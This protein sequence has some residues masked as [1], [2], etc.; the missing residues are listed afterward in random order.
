MNWPRIYLN[1]STAWVEEIM[2]LG[3]SQSRNAKYERLLFHIAYRKG[4]F[5]A[6]MI[7]IEITPEGETTVSVK[8]VKGKSCEKI[9]EAIEHA[10]GK[11][12]ETRR[13]SEYSAPEQNAQQVKANG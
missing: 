11:A 7:E 12:S 3:E 8:G 2:R 4:L 1:V 9:T 6:G 10:L 5:M 13:T